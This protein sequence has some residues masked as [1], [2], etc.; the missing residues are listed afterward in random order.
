MA[1]LFERSRRILSKPQRFR[2][3]GHGERF[4]IPLFT[5]IKQQRPRR[6]KKNHAEALR[7]R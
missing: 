3:E 6:A 4:S 1:E 2:N 7:T 5:L